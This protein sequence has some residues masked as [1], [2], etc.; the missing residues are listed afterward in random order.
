MPV[1]FFLKIS[2]WV[3]KEASVIGLKRVA[4]TPRPPYIRNNQE[5]DKKYT[6]STLSLSIL[7][8]ISGYKFSGRNELLGAF[9]VPGG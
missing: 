8:P 7:L 4:C 1:S 5:L 6:F 2:I 3:R 9:V